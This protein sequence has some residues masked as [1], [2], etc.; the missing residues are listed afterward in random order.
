[1]KNREWKFSRIARGA[2]LSLLGIAAAYGAGALGAS[3]QS[4]P[5]MLTLPATKR[6]SP[7]GKDVVATSSNPLQIGAA[8]S[9]A[10]TFATGS[11]EQAPVLEHDSAPT[12]ER[13]TR[14]AAELPDMYQAAMLSESRDHAWARDASH[15]IE[16]RIRELSKDGVVLKAV[17]CRTT[18]CQAELTFDSSD[19][20]REFLLTHL[21]RGPE[22]FL[23]NGYISFH[24]Q[25]ADDET[26]KKVLMFIS[27]QGFGLPEQL[28]RGAGNG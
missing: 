23:W 27:R 19:A 11:A 10:L 1:M 24:S 28:T 16:V 18:L 13:R 8:S 17:D 25:G 22:K 14:A 2:S 6:A 20:Y 3:Q 15:R 26:E 9:S 4:H 21:S 5:V 7:A 12:N